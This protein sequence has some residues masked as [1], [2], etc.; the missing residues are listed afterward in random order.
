MEVEALE[1]LASIHS[2]QL[3]TYLRLS[4]QPVGLLMNFGEETFRQGLRRVVN[5]MAGSS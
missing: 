1:R 3:L 4:R 2:A 5:S